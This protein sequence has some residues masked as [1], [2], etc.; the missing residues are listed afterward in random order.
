MYSFWLETNVLLVWEET[1]EKFPKISSGLHINL[2]SPNVFSV[3]LSSLGG[4][5]ESPNITHAVLILW[6]LHQFR[7]SE[8]V[9]QNP[10]TSKI[11]QTTEWLYKSEQSLAHTVSEE[12]CLCSAKVPLKPDNLD[13]PNLHKIILFV[14]LEHKRPIFTRYSE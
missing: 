10:A 2:L 8:H 13:Y 4:W 9:C 14:L 6:V 1:E 12:N 3:L 7:H 5:G 11:N